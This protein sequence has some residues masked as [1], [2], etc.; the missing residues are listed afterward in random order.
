MNLS[1]PSAPPSVFRILLVED[2][3]GDADLVREALTTASSRVQIEHVDSLAEAGSRLAAGNVDVVL[4]D[5]SLP[6]ATGLQAVERLHGSAPEVP[7]VVLTGIQDEVLGA[8]ALQA[9][10]Q[11]YLVKGQTDEWLLVRAMRYAIERQQIQADRTRLLAQEH[12]A[13]V[14]AEAHRERASFLAEA[15]QKLAGSLDDAG[16]DERL[17]EVA[18]LAVPRFADCCVI[19]RGSGST[20]KLV[21][22]EHVAPDKAELVHAL[23]RDVTAGSTPPPAMPANGE[24]ITPPGDDAARI[25]AA[26]SDPRYSAMVRDLAASSVMTAV[27][28]SHEGTAGAITFLHTSESGRHQSAEDRAMMQELARSASLAIENTRLHTEIRRAVVL[29][30]EFVAIASHELRTPLT[31]LM[32]Q[33]DLLRGLLVEVP[34][35]LRERLLDKHTK[36]H[37]QTA[38][39]EQLVGDL[40]DV[41][42]SS[43]S[44][45]T[46]DLE[47]VDLCRLARKVT[48]RLTEVASTAGCTVELRAEQPIL[49]RWDPRLLDRLFTNLLSNALKYGKGKGVEIECSTTPGMALMSVRDHGI[50]VAPADLERIFQRFERAVSTRQFSGLGLGLYIARNIAVA[51]GGSIVVSSELGQGATF[52]VSLP[53]VPTPVSPAR[54]EAP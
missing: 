35:P 17:S 30:E 49:G 23:Y 40:L 50:G 12:A 4:L 21:A 36:L 27:L 28:E 51:H 33:V 6:D 48:E 1:P 14:A 9:G 18:I 39:L 7:I 46:L 8:R 15:S 3:P 52:L 19:T 16:L 31:T 34:E 32:L 22:V 13:R 5:L 53:L 2:N 11:D 29:R 10:A 37:K 44:E 47:S 45:L 54:S 20:R 43:A 38:R 41:A 24:V 26:A 42:K 25:G